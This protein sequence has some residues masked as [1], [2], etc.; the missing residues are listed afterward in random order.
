M[1]VE[2]G[3]Q[4]VGIFLLAVDHH[5]NAEIVLEELLGEPIVVIAVLLAFLGEQLRQFFQADL[6]GL[7]GPIGQ[8]LTD[9]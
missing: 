7:D 6:R 9:Y 2:L 8:M 1:G 5:Q 3:E 4:R